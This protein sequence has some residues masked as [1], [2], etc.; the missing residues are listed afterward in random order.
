MAVRVLHTKVL[1]EHW[2]VLVEPGQVEAGLGG[3]AMMCEVWLPMLYRLGS[4]RLQCPVCSG[5]LLVKDGFGLHPDIWRG[6]SR[7][8]VPFV[9]AAL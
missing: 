5:Q 7:T 2:V 6:A 9:D 4:L 8:N 1:V 3:Q